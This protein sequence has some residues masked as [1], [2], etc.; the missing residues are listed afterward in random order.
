M[1]LFTLAYFYLARLFQEKQAK[2][3]LTNP[4]GLNWLA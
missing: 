1:E 2:L 4:V 3:F